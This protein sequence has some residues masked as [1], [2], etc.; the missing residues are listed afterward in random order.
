M[1]TDGRTWHSYQ[2]LFAGLRGSLKKPQ[3]SSV[4][5]SK[6]QGSIWIRPGA[7]TP[8][9][10][11]IHHSLHY[12]TFKIL[13]PVVLS[14]KIKRKQITT[15]NNFKQ[16]SNSYMFRPHTV[17]IRLALISS[18]MV[19]QWGRFNPL[20]AELNPICLLLALLGAHHIL[21]VSRI[22]VK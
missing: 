17:I 20:N 8:K 13:H 1:W 9:S 10:S 2:S 4:P 21:H 16:Y 6:R 5:S 3:F 22:R 11:Q 7:L 14:Y 19:T 15:E 12:F 18:L